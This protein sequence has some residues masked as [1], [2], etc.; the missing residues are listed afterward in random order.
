[1]EDFDTEIFIED[2]YNFWTKKPIAVIHCGAHLAEEASAYHEY[3]FSPVVWIEAAPNLIPSLQ[4]I[5]EKY[6]GDR[7]VQ[8]ALWSEPDVEKI[9][10]ISNNS[11][12]TSLRDFGTHKKTY[13]NIEFT[14][15]VTVKTLTLDEIGIPKSGRFLLVL[16]LQG[17]EYEVLLGAMET[18]KSCD[19]VYLEVSKRELY[20]GQATWDQVS[21]LLSTHGFSLIDWQYSE[22]FGWGNALYSR[23]KIFLSKLKRRL[24]SRRHI[25]RSQKVHR[26]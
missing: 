1:M 18:L 3:N 21:H 14:S 19:Y 17:I 5:V 12:S 15:E 25:V 26:N 9:L 7:V 24:R 11:Y 4:N 6:P 8:A 13:P 16:D 20:S 23:K 10:R 2:I 22:K